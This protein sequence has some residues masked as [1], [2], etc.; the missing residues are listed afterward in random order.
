MKPIYALQKNSEG[1]VINAGSFAYKHKLN[2]WL[3]D[4]DVR[5]GDTITF[6]EVEKRDQEE[7]DAA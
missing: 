7:E 1:A 3:R 6:G 5:A 2:D 4:I